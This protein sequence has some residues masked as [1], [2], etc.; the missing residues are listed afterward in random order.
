MNFG[1]GATKRLC[2]NLFGRTLFE[3]RGAVLQQDA[4]PAAF[5]YKPVLDAASAKLGMS[6][7]SFFYPAPPH[8]F[9]AL[10]CN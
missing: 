3:S 9:C 7:A 1:L 2:D 6:R 10:A 8:L 4:G 5:S